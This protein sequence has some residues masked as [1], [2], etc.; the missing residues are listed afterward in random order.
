MTKLDKDLSEVVEG[1]PH[2][3]RITLTLKK[4][5]LWKKKKGKE[6]VREKEKW[7]KKTLSASQHGIISRTYQA[8]EV[9]TSVTCKRWQRTHAF[10]CSTKYLWNVTQESDNITAS[11]EMA[12]GTWYILPNLEHVNISCLRKVTKGVQTWRSLRWSVPNPCGKSEPWDRKQV[13]TS[14]P[15]MPP[16]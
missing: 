5:V 8:K 15:D 14:R 6:I 3:R 2:F 7:R 13:P 9:Q 16:T 12:G 1:S 11:R 10:V 4:V